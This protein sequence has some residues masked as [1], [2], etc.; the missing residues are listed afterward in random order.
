MCAESGLGAGIGCFR[1]GDDVAFLGNKAFHVQCLVEM[2]RCYCSCEHYT[3]HPQKSEDVV[4]NEEKGCQSEIQIMCGVEEIKQVP[5]AVHHER[6]KLGRPYVEKQIQ[7]GR[8]TMYSLMGVGAY[9]GSGLNPMVSAH[10]W[11]IYALGAVLSSV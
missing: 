6:N 3:I 8:R 11:R 9:G 1:C 4:M 10:L 5:S 2:V 7:L